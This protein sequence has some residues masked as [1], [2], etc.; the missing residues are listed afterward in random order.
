MFIIQLRQRVAMPALQ[1][2]T[3]GW[4][5]ARC[6][7]CWCEIDLTGAFVQRLKILP[8]FLHPN[9]V[10]A[11]PA[12]LPAEEAAATGHGARLCV[13]LS[14]GTPSIVYILT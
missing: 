7:S 10:G 12:S 5:A 2:A 8:F 11:S 13:G 3:A 1:G 14:A 9:S 6:C 4:T